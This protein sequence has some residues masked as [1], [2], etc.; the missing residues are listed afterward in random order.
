MVEEVAFDMTH[1]SRE[2][3]KIQ[4]EEPPMEVPRPAQVTVLEEE[5]KVTDFETV[6]SAKATGNKCLKI[7]ETHLLVGT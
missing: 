1:P 2:E 4:I 5:S 6:R 7:K 3:E